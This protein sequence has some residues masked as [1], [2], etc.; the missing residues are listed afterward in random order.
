MLSGPDFLGTK[1]YAQMTRI[2]FI[3]SGGVSSIEDLEYL[4]TLESD[5]VMGAI[6]GRALYAGTIPLSILRDGDVYAC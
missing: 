6:V 3:A 4:S 2:P 1:R 5:G